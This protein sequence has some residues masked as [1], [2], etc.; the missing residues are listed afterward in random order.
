VSGDEVRFEAG[1]RRAAAD[2]QGGAAPLR[3]LPI[4]IFDS[5]VGGL[6]V[7]RAVRERLPR[8]RFLYLGDTARLPYGTKSAESVRR[9]SLQAA[10]LL[11]NR[12]IKYLLVACN[13]ASAV[14][15]DALR[16][17]YAPLP[18]MGVI[19]PG[20]EAACAASRSRQ[21]AVVATEGTIRGGAYQRSI[22]ARMP[23]ALVVGRAC[24][25]FVALAEEGWTDGP[26]VEAVAR[27]YLD[28]LFERHPAVDTLLLGCT[29]FPVL[30]DA[31]RKVLRE[32]VQLVDSARTTAL[33]L[34]RELTARGLHGS[35]PSG[36]VR[37]LATDNAERFAA[38]GSLFLGEPFAADA[39]EI[40][41]LAQPT[42]A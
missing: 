2:A 34:E 35:A 15:L 29:H 24:S 20:A 30:A 32:Q 10:D 6:T 17:R 26:I 22:N 33:A 25:L 40:V 27:R 23:D 1:T 36:S 39:V 42:S 5:G 41:D 19:D 37:L 21:I 28:E 8:E 12:G 38:V 14:A 18:V 9:Y 3:E 11:L 31:L 7:L 16:E 4:G 13:T